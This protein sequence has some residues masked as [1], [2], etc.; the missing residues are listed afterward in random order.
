MLINILY[1]HDKDQYTNPVYAA[2][3]GFFKTLNAEQPNIKCKTVEIS[4]RQTI[5]K[6]PLLLNELSA[7]HHQTVKY[8]GISICCHPPF[9][10]AVIF[11]SLMMSGT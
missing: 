1:V 2:I 4:S 11:H 9:L 6:A 8:D 7:G 5:E 10:I 3:G